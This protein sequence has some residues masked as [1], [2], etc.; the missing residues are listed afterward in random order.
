[1]SSTRPDLKEL[2]EE[3]M[4]VAHQLLDLLGKISGSSKC[5]VIAVFDAYRVQG[6][7]EKSLSMKNILWCLCGSPRC[8]PAY[9][10]FAHDNSKI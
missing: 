8:R 5:Q 4:D 2:A 9:G 3:N 7:H 6:H 1:M 10:K